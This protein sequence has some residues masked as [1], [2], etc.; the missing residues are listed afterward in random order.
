MNQPLLG[1]GKIGCFLISVSLVGGLTS[2]SVATR[3][4]KGLVLPPAADDAAAAGV[5]A[6]ARLFGSAGLFGA[7]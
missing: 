5:I 2:F 6:A 7:G 3:F 4:F 1:F